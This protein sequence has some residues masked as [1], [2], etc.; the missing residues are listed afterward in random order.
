MNNRWPQQEV[1]A[2]RVKEFCRR[3]GH[4]T[5]RGAVKMAVVADMFGLHVDTLRQ[6]LQDT[7]RKR[8]YIDTLIQISSVIGCSVTEFLDAPSDPPPGMSL[9][10][11]SRLTE[12]ERM[13]ASSLLSA[14]ASDDLSIA[15]KEVLHSNFQSLRDSLVE[16]RGKG[17][18]A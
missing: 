12:R 6:L 15:E 18:D 10:R 3:N 14:I 9:E 11:W 16:L 17:V 2:E 13:L 4:L 7:T 5:Q 1:F 8:P